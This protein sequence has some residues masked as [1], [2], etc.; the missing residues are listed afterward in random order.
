MALGNM[1]RQEKPSTSPLGFLGLRGQHGEGQMVG[2]HGVGMGTG[3]ELR[4]MYKSWISLATPSS[5][6]L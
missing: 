6:V 3:P 2:D 4:G 5:L 1:V